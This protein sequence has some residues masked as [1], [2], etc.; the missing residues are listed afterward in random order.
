MGSPSKR[1]TK[2]NNK[3]E[4]R[5]ITF[6]ETRHT[7]RKR[8]SMQDTEQRRGKAI[9]RAQATEYPYEVHFLNLK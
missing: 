5:T 6:M 2:T 3:D 8:S 7:G 9:A 4:L 1:L